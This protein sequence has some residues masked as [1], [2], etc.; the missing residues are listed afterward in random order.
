[1]ISQK[2]FL[3]ETHLT[4]STKQAPKITLQDARIKQAKMIQ[5]FIAAQCNIEVRHYQ[6][7]EYGDIKPS[8][9]LARRIANILNISPLAISNWDVEEAN[10]FPE[11]KSIIKLKEARKNVHMNQ[12]DV[13]R[14]CGISRRHYQSIEYG[15]VVPS[16]ILAKKIG[17]CLGISPLNI[18]EWTEPL[19]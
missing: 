15:T 19:Y 16:I 18:S 7:I 9:V 17:K 11:N 10:D 1:M 6:R 4:I 5:N 12:I 13:A 8:I 3:S 2:Q 14:Q